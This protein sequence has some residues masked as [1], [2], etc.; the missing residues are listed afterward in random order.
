MFYVPNF[1]NDNVWIWPYA[2][3]LWSSA[4]IWRR[5]AKRTR[6]RWSLLTTRAPPMC[7]WWWAASIRSP[8]FCRTSCGSCCGCSSTPISVSSAWFIRISSSVRWVGGRLLAWIQPG[9]IGVHVHFQGR[10]NR[11]SSVQALKDHISE[12]FLPRMR[13]WMVLFPEGGFLHKRKEVSRR[14]AEKNGLPDLQ[15]VSLPR[16]GALKAIFSVLPPLAPPANNNDET[17]TTSAMDSGVAA[18]DKSKAAAAAAVANVNGDDTVGVDEVDRRTSMSG[19]ASELVE[20]ISRE[21]VRSRSFKKQN[22]NS[23]GTKAATGVQCEGEIDE[24]PI[25]KKSHSIKSIHFSDNIKSAPNPTSTTHLDY[26]L[27]IT[28]AYPRGKPLDLS[29]IVTGIRDSFDTHFLYRLFPTSQVIV[30]ASMRIEC[31]FNAEP[32]KQLYFMHLRHSRSPATRPAS[33]NG[34]SIAGRKRSICWTSSI[35]PARLPRIRAP[36]CRSWCS[37]TCCV[38]WSSTCFSS[39]RRTFTCKW[40]MRWS[41]IATAFACTARCC[42]RAEVGHDEDDDGWQTM[43]WG[44]AFIRWCSNSISSSRQCKHRTSAKKNC[45]KTIE[46]RKLSSLFQHYCLSTIRSLHFCSNHISGFVSE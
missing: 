46:T 7:R 12:S 21:N 35:V 20:D 33:P 13:N 17:T 14:Y 5:V 43:S 42:R 23:N 39:R 38:S 32:T 18:A 6:A 36:W 45:T 15:H 27:D 41:A 3:K 22:G 26:I 34:C 29:S 19:N 24:H 16:V 44:T 31:K 25:K 28:I 4:T 30:I 2:R 8:T 9:L 1:R 37:R 11:D 40:S 10:D